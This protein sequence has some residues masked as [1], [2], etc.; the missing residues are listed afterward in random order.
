MSYFAPLIRRLIFPLFLILFLSSCTQTQD[1]SSMQSS[2]LRVPSSK[3]LNIRLP[4]SLSEP[5]LMQGATGLS[6][7]DYLDSNLKLVQPPTQTQNV[8]QVSTWEFNPFALAVDPELTGVNGPQVA[9]IMTQDD[10]PNDGHPSLPVNYGVN[11]GQLSTRWCFSRAIQLALK[12]IVSEYNVTTTIISSQAYHF[13]GL[14]PDVIH[15]F[16]NNSVEVAANV[17]GQKGLI[18]KFMYQCIADCDRAPGLRD[19]QYVMTFLPL[20]PEPG[21][22][23]DGD[24]RD[25]ETVGHVEWKMH[26]DGSLSDGRMIVGAG[27]MSVTGFGTREPQVI[28]E[29]ESDAGGDIREF[30]MRYVEYDNDQFIN[31]AVGV[32]LERM[33]AH[34]TGERLWLVQGM[35]PYDVLLGNPSGTA[36][37]FNPVIGKIG[38]E[39]LMMLFSAIAEDDYGAQVDGGEVVDDRWGHAMFNAVLVNY[40]TPDSR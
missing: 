16:V 19:H 10:C 39:D 15:E 24:P 17:D 23:I 3:Q 35:V 18:V 9:R 6:T 5:F 40:P 30:T 1:V 28:Y 33:A 13:D 8:S 34:D 22:Q 29:F 31:S 12:R 32:R 36:G 38:T 7:E 25:P 37:G 21:Y 26:A 27:M 2:E 4:K 20:V 11:G 14:E